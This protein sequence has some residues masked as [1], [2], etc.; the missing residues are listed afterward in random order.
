MN[1]VTFGKALASV[2]LDNKYDRF[3]KNRRTGKLDTKGLHRIDTSTKLFKRREARKNKH[4]AVSLVVDCSGSMSGSKIEMAAEA[5][6]KMSHHLSLIGIPHN[7][8]TFSGWVEE[9]KPFS[10]KEDKELKKKILRELDIPGSYIYH[11]NLFWAKN[12]RDSTGRY[13]KFL[14]VTKGI[15]EYNKFNDELDREGIG[16]LRSMGPQY[17][18]DGEALKFAREKLLKQ[19]GKKLMIFLSDGRPACIWDTL[20]SPNNPGTRQ[21]DYGV[22]QQVDATLRTGIELYSI[23]IMDDSVN[24]FYPPRRTCVIND[25]KQ[26]YPHIIKLIKINLKRG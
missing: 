4:Y 9:M 11:T 8:V 16:Y 21:S 2:M 12:L 26:L 13:W 10:Y 1:D 19:V 3:V 18:T 15:D 22:K 6:Q 25:I 23:G 7:I 14:K 17:N 24:K 20:E 5:A